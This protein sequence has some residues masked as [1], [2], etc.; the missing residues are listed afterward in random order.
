MTRPRSL[1]NA[2]Y[3]LP[4]AFLAVF[5]FY[6]LGAVIWESF[7]PGGRLDLAPVAALLREPYFGRVVWFTTWQAALSTILTLVIGLPAAY[8][9]ARYRCPGKTVLQAFTT[10]P[11]VLP[12]MVVAAAFT[13][14][15]GPRGW[16]N[17][18]L[19][20]GFGLAAGPIRLQYTLGLI[21]LAHAFYNTTVVIRVVGGF[22]ANLD[23]R[24]ADAARVLGGGRGRVFREI[25]APLLLPAIAA[26][27]LL[28]FIFCFTSFGVIL[29][30]GGPRFATLEVEIYRQAVTLF[31]LPEAA[32]LSLA[33][34]VLTSVVMAVYTRVQAR[35]AVPL[36]LRPAE[37]TA[38]PPVTPRQVALVAL[39]AI[40]L[41]AFLIAPLA[42][43]AGGSLAPGDPL[44]YYRE[45]FVN[46]TGSLFYVAP[47][48]AI[49]NSLFFAALTT[50]LALNIGT[51]TAYLL[52]RDRGRLGRLLDPIF[53][54]PLG[55]SAVTLGFGYI[56]AL[57]RP[58]FNLAAS[59]VLVPIAHTLV[60]FPFVVR[61]LLPALRRLNPDWRE[62]AAVL[63]ASPWRVWR[64]VELPI[65]GRALLVA[66]VFA[67][68]VS[69][70]EFGATLLIARPEFPTMPVVIF[71]LLGQPGS[72]NYGQALAMSTLLMA[73]CAAGFV[74][75][76]RFRVGE[77]GEF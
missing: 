33:Q 53:L 52:A 28:V 70:G 42:A 27:G 63:G 20:A 73:V 46:R 76:E 34:I 24:L 44:R 54:L 43:L 23:P 65:V 57:G 61:T 37:A 40:G 7:A 4:L 39:T 32:G 3:L 50:L 30:L 55:T 5:F 60:A 29:I 64:E 49:R 22:W 11:F 9:F 36:N 16:L 10:I 75:I 2:L 18:A 77:V 67:F 47:G 48:L 51:I 12:A 35:A 21:L 59:P 68:T 58:P 38:Q 13:A 45:L 25:T 62:S 17:E 6:P 19:A 69:M 71:R 56:L 66:A 74:L 41:L 14:L 26:A 15:L 31:R 8:V 72:L 1:V